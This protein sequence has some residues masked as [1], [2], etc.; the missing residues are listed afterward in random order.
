MVRE[1][2]HILSA[3]DENASQMKKNKLTHIEIEIDIYI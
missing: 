1:K 3:G 2:K